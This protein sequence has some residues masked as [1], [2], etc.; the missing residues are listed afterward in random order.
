MEYEMI[1]A[2]LQSS[3]DEFDQYLRTTMSANLPQYNTLYESMNYSLLL[4]GKRIRPILTKMVLETFFLDYAQY[5]PSISAIE[6][7]HTYSLVHDDLPAMD[8]DDYRR[9]QETNHKKYGEG[10]AILAGDGLLTFAFQLL[11]TDTNT[12]DTQKVALVKTLSINAGPEGM[13]GGQ[14]FDLQSE[15][16]NLTLKDLIALHRGKTGALFSASIEVGIILGSLPPSMAAPLRSYGSALGLL[17]QITDDILDVTGTAESIGKMP[18]SD[19]KQQKATYVSLLGLDKAK[20]EAKKAEEI[21]LQS[22]DLIE[23]DT[24]LLRQLIHYLG[25]RTN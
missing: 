11:C 25:H 15:G 9:G 2:Y 20:E 8:N 10:M 6:F 13:V 18:G 12:T 1:T 22:L 19:M 5:M 14:S 24:Q 3:K 17:F 4:G 16:K 7:I 23:A 21:A